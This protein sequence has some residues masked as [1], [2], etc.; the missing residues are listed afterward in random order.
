MTRNWTIRAEG[1]Y[2][3]L[4]NGNNRTVY[5]THGGTN[6]PISVNSGN[7]GGV[8]RVGVNYKF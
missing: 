7:G 1:L 2:V 5:V 6:Y 8:V 4:S 3:N